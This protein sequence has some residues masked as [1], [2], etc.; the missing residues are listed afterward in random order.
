MPKVI[1]KMPDTTKGSVLMGVVPRC[2]TV[3][4]ATPMAITNMPTHKSARRSTRKTALRTVKGSRGSRPA[5]S[6]AAAGVSFFPLFC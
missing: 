2:A 5:P 6:P 3:T 4:S 1:P